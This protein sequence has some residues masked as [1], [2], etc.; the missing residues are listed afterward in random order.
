MPANRSGVISEGSITAVMNR[1]NDATITRTG[2]EPNRPSPRGMPTGGNH[3][4]HCVW[5]T[6]RQLIRSAG[7]FGANSGLSCATFLRNQDEEPV[8]PTRS[9]TTTRAPTVSPSAADALRLRIRRRPT[10][11]DLVDTAAALPPEPRGSRSPATAPV[12]SQSPAPTCP[13]WREANPFSR[14]A[15]ERIDG[16]VQGGGPGGESANCVGFR[17]RGRHCP[18]QTLRRRL[19][20]APRVYRGLAHLG[21]PPVPTG[22]SPPS[23]YTLLRAFRSGSLFIGPGLSNATTTVSHA[24]WPQPAKMNSR[25]SKERRIRGCRPLHHAS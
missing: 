25:G 22:R 7:S 6:A 13:H 5:S 21:N 14:N 24:R 16:I 18:L 3:R 12:A 10:G 11:S 4:S 23:M 8:Q 2:G 17:S 9:A 20:C 1:D 19:F 15:Q